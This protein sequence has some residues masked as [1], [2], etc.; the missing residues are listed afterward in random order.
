MPVHIDFFH[1]NRLAIVVARGEVTPADVAEAVRQLLESGALHYRKIL[2]ISSPSR[3]LTTEGIEK[4]AALLRTAPNAETRGPLA[5]V[6]NRGDQA[7]RAELFAKM[8]AGE[9]PVRVF[10]SLHEA[11]RWLE[12]QPLGKP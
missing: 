11:R 2:D 5:I 12:Q 1:P 7:E 8:T 10:H 3:P 4:I 9:R 6:I